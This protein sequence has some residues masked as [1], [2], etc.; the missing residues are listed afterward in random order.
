M[1]KLRYFLVKCP[2]CG[3][4]TGIRSSGRTRVCPYCGGR[5]TQRN[6]VNRDLYDA[7]ELAEIVR[8]A[9][10]LLDGAEKMGN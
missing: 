2:G 1:S 10:A 5:I 8:S 9:N 7:V 3:R 4:F 6:R